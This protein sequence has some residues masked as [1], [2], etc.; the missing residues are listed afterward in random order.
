M[1]DRPYRVELALAAGRQPAKL[2]ADVQR[3]IVRALHALEVEPRPDGVQQ[4][5]GI[6]GAPQWRLRV[7]DYRVIYEIHDARLLVLVIR[8]GHRRDVYRMP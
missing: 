8:I 4:L 7:G 3:R 6:R 1:A 2:S 5:S